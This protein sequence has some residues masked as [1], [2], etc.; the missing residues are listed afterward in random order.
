MHLASLLTLRGLR[1]EGTEA[2]PVTDA[3]VDQ[4]RTLTGCNVVRVPM[5]KKARGAA[6][7]GPRY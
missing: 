1:L 4:F 3:E 7:E 6:T 5:R 2:T